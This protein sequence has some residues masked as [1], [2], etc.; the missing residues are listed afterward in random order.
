MNLNLENKIVLITG[1]SGGIGV[2][3]TRGFLNE[4]AI[5]LAG[6]NSRIEPLEKL[7]A[8]CDSEMKT[9]IIPVQIDMRKPIQF[10]ELLTH[11]IKRFNRIDV[12]INAVGHAI[13][14]P[15]LL[16][17]D[18]EID[19][20]IQDNFTSQVKFTKQ[21]IKQMMFQKSGNVINISSLL[22]SRF[23]RGVSVY[24][25]S[26]AAT[27]R[28]TKSLAMEVGKKGIRV[29]AVCP[30]F[31]QTKM[32]SDLSKNMP[33]ELLSLSPISRPGQPGEIA[34]AILFLASDTRASYITGVT[35]HVDGGFGI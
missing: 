29:N 3:I 22:G 35:L 33:K 14:K 1:A 11:L 18:E 13:E 4:G 23:G 32:T 2:E 7:I 19:S 6:Y 20:Q 21:I 34:D 9:R 8:E 27:E 12:L 28:F 24:A 30:G 16:M 25:A 10:Q 31:I 15:L 26:K 17:E 5:V